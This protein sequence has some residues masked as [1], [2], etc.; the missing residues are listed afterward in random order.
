[1]SDAKDATGDQQYSEFEPG[2]H[3]YA[4]D[5]FPEFPSALWGVEELTVKCL[6][7]E[8]D[9]GSPCPGWEET[10]EI[11]PSDIKL[12]GSGLIQIDVDEMPSDCPECGNPYEF[13]YNGVVVTKDVV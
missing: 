7:G 5:G 11:D 1:M 12:D 2:M 13:S 8:M 9:P 4:T 10:Y 6:A 3:A